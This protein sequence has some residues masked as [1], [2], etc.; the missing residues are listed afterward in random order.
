VIEG[1]SS[2]NNDGDFSGKQKHLKDEN[3]RWMRILALTRANPPKSIHG[4]IKRVY[5]LTLIHRGVI[6]GYKSTPGRNNWHNRGAIRIRIRN[7]DLSHATL[8]AADTPRIREIYFVSRA[9]DTTSRNGRFPRP[10]RAA[11]RRAAPR[12][13]TRARRRD[14][15]SRKSLH[16]LDVEFSR[17]FIAG[18]TPVGWNLR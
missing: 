15:A 10:R 8:A 9:F 13:T 18:S 7:K 5:A 4:L 17:G 6:S 12:G 2:I 11:P 16:N 14:P 1:C 3:R